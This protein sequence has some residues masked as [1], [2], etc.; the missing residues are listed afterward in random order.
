M[1]EFRMLTGAGFSS[2]GHLEILAPDGQ[3]VDSGYFRIRPSGET[4]Y[5]VCGAPR[6]LQPMVAYT[7]RVGLCLSPLAE[8]VEA[9]CSTVLKEN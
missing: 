2:K 6:R 1:G 9:S 4:G 7:A 5:F 8:S 3:A